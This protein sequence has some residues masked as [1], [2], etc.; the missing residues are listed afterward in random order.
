MGATL[1][2]KSHRKPL[3]HTLAGAVFCLAAPVI[4]LHAQSPVP[5]QISQPVPLDNTYPTYSP[6]YAASI[7]TMDA[8]NNERKL[9]VGDQISYR[10]VEEQKAPL[11]LVVRD[12]GE[13]DVPLL[14]LVKAAGKTCKEL[15]EQLKPLLEKDYFYK[16]TVIIGLDTESTRSLGKVYIMGQVHTQGSVELPSNEPLTVSQAVLMNGGLADFADKHH[17]KLIRKGP[18]GKSVTTNVDIDAVYRGRSDKDP[19]LQPGDTINVT[20]KLINF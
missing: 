6:S 5:P 9:S 13:V 7:D 16:A 19:V 2:L 14:G 3:L 12:S 17:V 18:D 15:A 20:E 4:S 8:L 11:P 1:P 10:V